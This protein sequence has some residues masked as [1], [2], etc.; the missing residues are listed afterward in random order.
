METAKARRKMNSMRTL[1]AVAA[2]YSV[3][4]STRSSA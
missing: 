4:Q 1:A 3:H 2:Y